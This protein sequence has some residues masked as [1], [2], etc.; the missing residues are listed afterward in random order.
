MTMRVDWL[1]GCATALVTPFT[2][3]G[4]V[5]EARMRALLDRQIAGGVRLLVPC[6]TTGEG[7]T[8]TDDEQQRVIA[9]TV[10]VARGRARVI[11]G[12]GSNSTAVTVERARAAKAAGSDAVLVVAPYYNKPTQTGL[13]AHFTAVAEAV[14]GLPV[15]LYNVPGR[16]ASNVAATTTLQLAREVPNIAGTKEASGD[17]AQI[18]AI[19][20]DRP[21][22]FRVLSGDDA[23]TLPLIALGADGIISVVSNEVPDMMAR[24]T[25]LALAGDFASARAIQYRLL[26]L[27]EANFIESNPG[28]VKAAMALMGLLEE[29]FR[30]PL[31]PVQEKTRARLAEVLKELGLL[32]RAAHVAA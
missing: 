31:V 14:P 29:Q 4:A 28:P 19:L 26:P 27:M 30:L 9:L 17:F 8:L 23:V 20:R 13:V 32:S 2:A 6:G 10:E 25:D 16:T 5:D 1:T 12:V 22:G 18:M 24:L 3:K 11:A 7:A 21:E 15:V